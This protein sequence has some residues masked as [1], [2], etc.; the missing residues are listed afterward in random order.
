MIT[1]TKKFPVS[2]SFGTSQTKA[3]E[4]LIPQVDGQAGVFQGLKSRRCYPYGAVSYLGKDITMNDVFAK[5]VDSGQKIESVERTV[6]MLEYYL[7]ALQ[8]Y[9]IGNIIGIEPSSEEPC[10]FRLKK[11]ADRP[12]TE[13]KPLP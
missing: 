3:H 5:L 2:V 1:K 12:P 8:D 7:T 10:G 11:V 9:K 4:F 6:K 13:T